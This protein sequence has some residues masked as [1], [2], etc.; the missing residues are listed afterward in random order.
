MLENDLHPGIVGTGV[1]NSDADGVARLLRHPA[2]VVSNSDSGA[3]IQMLCADGDTTLLLTRFVRERGD[4]TLEA[5]VR[6]LTVRQAEVFG[7]PDRGT[8]RVGGAGDLT[9]FALD[10]LSWDAPVFVDDLPLGGR[11]MRRPAGG[12]RATIV[13]GVPTQLDGELT[14]ARPGHLL[15]SGRSHTELTTVA[16]HSS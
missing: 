10:E 11:R 16:P 8:V 3:H 5:A 15:R 12:Y 2:A 1:A 14:G 7:Y 13:V 4:L 6:Q 9:V